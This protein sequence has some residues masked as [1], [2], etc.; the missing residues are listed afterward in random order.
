VIPS[1]PPVSTM[2]STSPCSTTGMSPTTG[3]SSTGISTPN[4]SC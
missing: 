1:T 2:G 3:M 4:G